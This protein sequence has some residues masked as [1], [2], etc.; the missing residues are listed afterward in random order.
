MIASPAGGA[1]VAQAQLMV[2]SIFAMTLSLLPAR[3]Q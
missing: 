2:Y 1:T 3:A